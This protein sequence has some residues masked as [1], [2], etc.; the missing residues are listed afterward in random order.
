MNSDGFEAILDLLHKVESLQE[1]FSTVANGSS[2]R[3]RWMCV[4]SRRAQEVN[5]EL[6]CVSNLS[7]SKSANKKRKKLSS[8]SSTEAASS[9]EGKEDKA[10]ESERSAAMATN[11][12]VN[13][14]PSLVD[15]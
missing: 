3:G 6:K 4:F 1:Q 5:F 7:M 15:V 11:E 13:E 10:F 12:S 8:S 9:T 14:T 2:C